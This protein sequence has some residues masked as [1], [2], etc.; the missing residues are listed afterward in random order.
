MVIEVLHAKGLKHGGAALRD[1]H[2]KYWPS[3]PRSCTWEWARAK[4]LYAL[5]PADG[6]AWKSSR[7]AIAVILLVLRL[8]PS[9]G[10]SVLVFCLAFFVLDHSDEYMLVNYILKFKSFQFFA[11]GLYP[12][13]KLGLMTASCMLDEHRGLHDACLGAAPGETVE[14]KVMMCFEPVRI[15]L[16]YTA[17]FQLVSGRAYGGLYAIRALHKNRLDAADGCL[18]GEVDVEYLRQLRGLREGEEAAAPAPAPAALAGGGATCAGAATAGPT[19]AGAGAGGAGGAGAGPPAGV[20]ASGASAAAPVADAGGVP[21]RAAM[22]A[23]LAIHRE[24]EGAEIKH[25]KLLP[26][27]MAYDLL[28]LGAV[29]ALGLVIIPMRYGFL[30]ERLVTLLPLV[31]EESSL[32]HTLER[33]DDTLHSLYWAAVYYSDMV[34]ALAAL[35]FLIFEAPIIGTALHGAKKTGYDESGVLAPKLSPSQLKAKIKHDE[36]VAKYGRTAAAD[37]K[38]AALIIQ[39]QQERHQQRLTR[40]RQ[41][42]AKLATVEQPER[43]VRARLPIVD[44][45]GGAGDDDGEGAV[46][47]AVDALSEAAADGLSAGGAGAAGGGGGAAA[48]DSAVGGANPSGAASSAGASAPTATCALD[49]EGRPPSG[50]PSRASSG[51]TTTASSGAAGRGVGPGGVGSAVTRATASARSPP[52]AGQAQYAREAAYDA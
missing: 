37:R 16:V 18:D 5:Y 21:S 49:A 38:R 29:T 23:N 45:D 51:R 2:I 8:I 27:F 20:A 47:S 24:N 35:P 6:N 15:V 10:I 22:V 41:Q 14:F 36:E 13:V 19:G 3:A 31:R 28:C 30:P 9:Y 40:P 7:D 50:P 1:M 26:A 48:A 25:G 12:A 39:R 17:L 33:E 46:A 11:N 43:P 44:D 4:F 32:G 34:Y 52:E 42:P